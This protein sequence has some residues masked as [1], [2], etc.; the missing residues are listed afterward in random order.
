[1]WM[2]LCADD[3]SCPKQGPLALQSAAAGRCRRPRQ[4]AED[5]QSPASCEDKNMHLKT[6]G[7]QRP[8]TVA[9]HDAQIPCC[10]PYTKREQSKH[11]VSTSAEPLV[12]NHGSY[13]SSHVLLVVVLSILP[14]FMCV[15]PCPSQVLP[16][17]HSN[18]VDFLCFLWSAGTSLI[19]LC[20]RLSLHRLAFRPH[21]SQLTAQVPSHFVN[22][23]C[24]RAAEPPQLMSM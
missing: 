17:S 10:T 21:T 9:A 6:T 13:G 5:V 2:A 22:H 16:F 15:P 23:Q 7:L 14:T 18:M 4:G 12:A 8:R 11:P 1:M 19:P 3:T 24:D 20:A